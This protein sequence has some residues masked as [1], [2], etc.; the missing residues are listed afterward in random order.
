MRRIRSR[1]GGNQ[2]SM[3]SKGTRKPFRLHRTCAPLGNRDRG[4]NVDSNGNNYHVE[5]N[6]GAMTSTTGD[7]LTE[8]SRRRPGRSR[9]SGIKTGR[10]QTEFENCTLLQTLPSH[11]P[12]TQKETTISE[13]NSLFRTL[14]PLRHRQESNRV[15]TRHS[16]R[17]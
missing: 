10:L 11:V 9:T 14:S 5:T 3:H 6:E 13:T 12:E 15:D 1:T 16:K 4:L 8:P 7:R 17:G 2:P